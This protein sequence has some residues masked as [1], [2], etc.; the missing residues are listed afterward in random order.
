MT[1]RQTKP[2]KSSQILQK[3]HSYYLY[4]W[5]RHSS[6]NVNV[7]C[8]QSTGTTSKAELNAIVESQLKHSHGLG[9][10]SIDQLLNITTTMV[11]PVYQSHRQF[12]LNDFD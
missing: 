7:N 4:K 8:V 3:L 2:S 12:A 5:I 6:T 9:Y 1:K 11:F 10:Y